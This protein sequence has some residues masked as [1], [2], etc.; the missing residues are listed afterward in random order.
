[1]G[2][3]KDYKDT[4]S[5][6]GDW[7]HNLFGLIFLP[8]VEVEN[9]F[10]EDFM[11]DKPEDRRIDELCDYLV[12]NY[13]DNSSI[14]PRKLW[15]DNSSSLLRTTNSCESFHSKFSAY[16]PSPHPN[17]AIFLET[18]QKM[19]TDTYIKINSIMKNEKRYI[20]RDIINKQKFLESKIMQYR[21][22]EISRY[23]FIKCVAYKFSNIV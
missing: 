16:C 7:L 15:A 2:L 3:T 17:I 12:E 4:T 6:I 13:I 10:V 18:L 23:N 5:S 20:R 21:R 1:M 11:A 8:P 22:K 19:Q 14:F 9:S